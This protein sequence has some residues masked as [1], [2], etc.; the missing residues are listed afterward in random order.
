MVER[1]ELLRRLT[2]SLGELSERF[3]TGDF[4]GDALL[5]MLLLFFDSSF[6]LM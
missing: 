1:S 5:I 4:V 3:G 2:Q 6:L